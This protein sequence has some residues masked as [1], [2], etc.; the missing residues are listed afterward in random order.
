VLQS[1]G[2]GDVLELLGGEV[3]EGA[4]RGGEDDAAEPSLGQALDDLESGFWFFGFWWVF[5]WKSAG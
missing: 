1:V 5:F 3:A 2:D 4:S